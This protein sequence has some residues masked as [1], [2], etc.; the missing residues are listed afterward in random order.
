LLGNRERIVDLDTK[1]S[2]SALD[3]RVSQQQLD[4]AQIAGAPVDQCGLCAPD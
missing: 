4:R 2:D 3:L 1:V